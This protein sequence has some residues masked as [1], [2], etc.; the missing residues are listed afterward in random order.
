MQERR[1]VRA[2]AAVQV[3]VPCCAAATRED[4]C[5]MQL[6]LQFCVGV[7]VAAGYAGWFQGMSSC[8]SGAL[9]PMYALRVQPAD[10]AEYFC[11]SVH[12]CVGL[13]SRRVHC[14]WVLRKDKG[15]GLCAHRGLHA[16]PCVFRL[17]LLCMVGA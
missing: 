1:G 9:M 11:D 17:V 3:C 12:R 4:G 13:D 14:L 10:N 15:M 5:G 8:R 7:F 2:A 6:S 16:T